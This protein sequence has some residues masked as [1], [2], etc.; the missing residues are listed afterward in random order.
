M[1][2]CRVPTRDPEVHVQ[3]VLLSMV[4][5]LFM[6]LAL[7]GMKRMVGFDVQNQGTTLVA[8]GG[9]PSPVETYLDGGVPSPVE[10][11]R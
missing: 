11:A 2:T 9:V 5:A 8:D 6:A 1:Y 7:L 3:K 4:L 10:T